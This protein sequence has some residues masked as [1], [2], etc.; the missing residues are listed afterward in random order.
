MTPD[1]IEAVKHVA[2]AIDVKEEI[3]EQIDSLDDVVDCIVNQPG[4]NMEKLG[5]VVK[6]NAGEGAKLGN[7]KAKRVRQLIKFA[8]G[9]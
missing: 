2:H 4:V 1:E 9:D 6:A 8:L 7:T 3:F 5:E